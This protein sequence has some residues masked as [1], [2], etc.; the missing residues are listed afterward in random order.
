MTSIIKYWI[1][2]MQHNRWW[3]AITIHNTTRQSSS[4]SFSSPVCR[5]LRGTTAGRTFF[6]FV[7]VFLGDRSQGAAAASLKH[8]F[9]DTRKG[10][11][12]GKCTC[13]TVDDWRE[14]AVSSLKYMTKRNLQKRRGNIKMELTLKVSWCQVDVGIL[15]NGISSSKLFPTSNTCCVHDC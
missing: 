1:H 9:T 14:R 4:S 7:L 10:L 15:S 3:A 12:R 11:Q 5:Q 8:S 2:D 6:Q 13:D